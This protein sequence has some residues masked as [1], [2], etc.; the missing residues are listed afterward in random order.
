MEISSSYLRSGLSSNKYHPNKK[1][2]SRGKIEVEEE[3]KL[4]AR[5]SYDEFP[6]YLPRIKNEEVK[7]TLQKHSR[8]KRILRERRFARQTIV[9]LKRLESL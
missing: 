9:Q 5:K 4:H 1:N 6:V 2:Y 3:P 8:K 7:I